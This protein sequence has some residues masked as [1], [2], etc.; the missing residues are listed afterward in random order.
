MNDKKYF[1]IEICAKSKLSSTRRVQNLPI[2]EA[3][4]WDS[5]VVTGSICTALRH[6]RRLGDLFSNNAADPVM[7]N[8][9]LLPKAW[10]FQS[11]LLEDFRCV[12]FCVLFW[13]AHKW[14]FDGALFSCLLRMIMRVLCSWDWVEFNMKFVAFIFDTDRCVVAFGCKIPIC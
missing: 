14:G 8:Y 4:Y 2:W 12:H 3:Q 10:F 9:A 5:E 6:R 13:M 7:M 11:L 1:W